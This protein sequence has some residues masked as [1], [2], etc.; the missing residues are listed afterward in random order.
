MSTAAATAKPKDYASDQE[1]RWC[2]GCGDYAILKAMQKTL[3]EIGP[4]QARLDG[5]LAFSENEAAKLLGIEKHALR[6][7]RLR[8]EVH[9]SKIGKRIVYSREELQRLLS[10]SQIS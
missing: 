3:A 4:Q 6:D 5:K 8:G 10:E 1:V 9:A 2:P 7:A